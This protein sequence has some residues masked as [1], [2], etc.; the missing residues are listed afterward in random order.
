MHPKQASTTA[1]W[2]RGGACIPVPLE[3]EHALSAI[4]SRL[5]TVHFLSPRLTTKGSLVLPT[6]A[7]E[8]DCT[9][10]PTA[11]KLCAHDYLKIPAA[12]AGGGMRDLRRF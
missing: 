1:A 8:P 3:I 11:I 10:L 9:P 2:L 5:W 7:D 4:V 12:R 6:V